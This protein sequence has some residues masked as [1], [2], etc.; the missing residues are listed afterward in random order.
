MGE[1]L[2]AHTRL[3]RPRHEDRS[4]ELWSRKKMA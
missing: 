1:E 4:G 2:R 3:G